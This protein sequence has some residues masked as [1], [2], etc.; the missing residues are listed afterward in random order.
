[1]RRLRLNTVENARRTFARLLRAYDKDEIEPQKF[2]NLC[3]GFAT[4]LSFFKCE[5]ELEIVNRMA[6][7][8]ERVKELDLRKNEKIR[9]TTVN[10]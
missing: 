2:R 9:D 6:A 3:F 10:D 8:E 1:M 7:L 4:F 5:T